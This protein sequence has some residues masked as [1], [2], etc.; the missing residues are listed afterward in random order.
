MHEIVTTARTLVDDVAAAHRGRRFEDAVAAFTGLLETV[1]DYGP[2]ELAASDITEL[3][4]LA[5]VVIRLIE[6]RLDARHDGAGVQRDLAEA[7]YCIRRQ[8]EQMD[9]WRRHYLAS[10]T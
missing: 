8:L 9:V 3:T 2:T 4:Q 5:E 10:K 7:V 1:P 6:A